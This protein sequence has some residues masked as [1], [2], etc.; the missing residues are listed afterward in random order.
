VRGPFNVNVPAQLAA[1][2]ALRDRAHVEKSIAH[3]DRWKTFL[4]ENIRALG[5][6]VDD[7]VGNFLLI[8]F[9]PN[10]GR[11]ARDADA[12]LSARG[13]VLRGVANYG[14]PHCLRLT[15]GSE[16]A[17]TRVVAALADFMGRS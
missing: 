17:N 3:N 13:L 4:V 16:G 14:L 10:G 11:S 2:A 6:R 1:A 8:H 12:F 5:L 7:S 9:E 15:I